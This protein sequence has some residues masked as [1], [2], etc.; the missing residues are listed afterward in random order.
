MTTAGTHSYRIRVCDQCI[1][2]QGEMCHNPACVFCRRTMEEVGECL[3]VLL[4]RP[5][6]DGKRVDEDFCR[7]K[8]VRVKVTVERLPERG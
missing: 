8:A 4:I 2:L 1:A 6:I 7:E 5:V 3:D